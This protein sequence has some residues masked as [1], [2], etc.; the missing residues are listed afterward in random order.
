MGTVQEIRNE[1]TGWARS[2]MLCWLAKISL[3]NCKSNIYIYYICNWMDNCLIG[4]ELYI[5][6]TMIWTC[7]CILHPQRN[8]RS[9][10]RFNN[11]SNN[12]GKRIS[13]LT[14]QWQH[15]TDNR[16]I[17][18][19]IGCQSFRKIHNV[20]TSLSLQNL[21]SSTHQVCYHWSDWWTVS[22]PVMM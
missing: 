1:P 2:S 15:K 17:R 19:V 10:I 16:N 8:S 3:R 6:F 20:S 13:F 12:L 21:I 18:L 9:K 22:T 7:R 14:F 5:Y 11:V 4:S